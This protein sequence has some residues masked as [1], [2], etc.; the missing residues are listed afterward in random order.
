MFP[1]SSHLSLVKGGQDTLY[2]HQPDDD[3]QNDFWRMR[4][5]RRRSTFQEK[6]TSRK[7]IKSLSWSNHLKVKE[8]TTLMMMI[9][10]VK[11]KHSLAHILY[12]VMRQQHH[13]NNRRITNKSCLS[14]KRKEI[15]WCCC[16]SSSSRRLH[17]DRQEKRGYFVSENPWVSSWY[18]VVV[19]SVTGSRVSLSSITTI[20]FMYH[21][22]L[23][24]S[25]SSRDDDDWRG[26]F[27]TWVSWWAVE[28][29]DKIH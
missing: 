27:S 5:R 6:K 25:L 15:L 12:Q 21:E 29:P 24:F 10:I 20:Y 14:A 28:T 17:D 19:L 16:A 18:F 4:G 23:F 9:I 7:W 3:V 11:T 2:S 22:Y 13:Y 8:T 26:D 1:S